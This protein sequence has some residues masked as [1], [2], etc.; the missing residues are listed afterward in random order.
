P[1][2]LGR[3]DVA[4]IDH[5][6]I[7]LAFSTKRDRLIEIRYPDDRSLMQ[8]LKKYRLGI[9]GGVWLIGSIGFVLLLRGIYRAR[10]PKG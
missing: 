8:Y 3:G 2:E 5:R 10:R 1:Q 6:G 4:F 9:I 7:N